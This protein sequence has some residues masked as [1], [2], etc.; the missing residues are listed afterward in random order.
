MAITIDNTIWGTDPTKAKTAPTLTAPGASFYP[1]GAR[2]GGVGG[3]YVC[4]NPC[5]TVSQ[6]PTV[7]GQHN[8]NWRWSTGAS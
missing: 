3:H 4:V 6:P 2:V 1:Q 5:G 8:D 7:G